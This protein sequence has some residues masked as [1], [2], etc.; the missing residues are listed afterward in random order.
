MHFKSGNGAH[1]KDLENRLLV[2]IKGNFTFIW[3][4]FIILLKILNSTRGKNGKTLITVK[5]WRVKT[6]ANYIFYFLNFSISQ[7]YS[8]QAKA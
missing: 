3:N 1:G 5:F 8:Y 7:K 2:V 4:D 6:H